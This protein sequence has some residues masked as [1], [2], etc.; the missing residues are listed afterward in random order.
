M[1]DSFTSNYGLRKIDFNVI[2][3]HDKLNA[4]FDKLDSVIKA[5]TGAGAV[6]GTWTN[7]TTYAVADR[8]FDDVTSKLY[9]CLVAHTSAATG[10]FEQDRTLHPT[11]WAQVT[12]GLVNR[13]GWVTAKAYR[14][15]DLVQYNGSTWIAEV[16]HTSGVFATDQGAGKWSVFAAQGAGGGGSGDFNGPASST[17]DAI[18]LFNGAG[19]KTGKDSGVLL[20]ALAALASPTFTGNPAAP[21]QAPGDNSTKLATTGFVTAAVNVVLGG[22]DAAFDTLAEIATALAGKLSSS[23]NLGD[24]A[25]AATAFAAIK[26]PASDTATGVVELA[27]NSEATAQSSAALVLVPANLTGVVKTLCEFYPADQEYFGSNF[28]T[29]NTRNSHP[30]LEFDTTTQETAIFTGCLPYN[31]KTSGSLVVEVY[32]AMASATSGTVGFDAAFERIDTNLDIDADSFASA[33]TITATT[34]PST[35]GQQLRL[36]VTFGSSEIDGLVAGEQFRLRLRRDVTNDTATGDA[37]VT[38]V[39]V[40]NA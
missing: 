4:N 14:V 33:K 23:A 9:D 2:P 24:V 10:T 21:T 20:S 17:P 26:Q 40:R 11:Y 28:A 37:Q 39:E 22:V 30:I 13:G 8:V 18:V 38:K 5:A 3:W 27:T 12:S 31:Y 32:V 6:D 7:G 16:N 36:T 25:N 15:Q 1:A 29:Y 19:G 34:V 35:S